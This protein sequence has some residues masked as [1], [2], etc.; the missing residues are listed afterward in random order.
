MY[1]LV[2]SLTKQALHSI[3]VIQSK[4]QKT[5]KLLKRSIVTA[6][7]VRICADGGANRIYD[8]APSW[9]SQQEPLS[10][11][12][13]FLPDV[14]TGDLDSIRPDVASFYSQQGIQCVS[15]NP[16]RKYCASIALILSVK[17]FDTKEGSLMI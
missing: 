15:L 1:S 10:A 11:R 2:A 8:K 6:A 4:S 13:H 7:S 12:K 14:I 16:G 3:K 9:T 17:A 5:A